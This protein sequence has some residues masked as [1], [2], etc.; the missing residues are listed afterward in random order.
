MIGVGQ[1]NSVSVGTQLFIQHVRCASVPKAQEIIATKTPNHSKLMWAQCLKPGER[2]RERERERGSLYFQFHI[3]RDAKN[4]RCY[5]P[6][7]IMN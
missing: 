6:T 4:R 3:S 7:L 1:Y 5:T 2:E